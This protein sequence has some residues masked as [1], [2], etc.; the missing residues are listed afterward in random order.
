MRTVKHF[1][2]ISMAISIGLVNFYC[3]ANTHLADKRDYVLNCIPVKEDHQIKT[4][5]L[6]EAMSHFKV[7]AISFAVMQN[8][9]ISWAD[10]I[11]YTDSDHTKKLIRI[12]Y[13]KLDQCQSPLPQ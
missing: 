7:P 4:I 2:L 12:R 10:A 9:K 8:D 5:S 3:Y 11:G 1:I 13:F 6:S